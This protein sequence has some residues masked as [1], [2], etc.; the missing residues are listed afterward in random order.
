MLSREHAIGALGAG[1]FDV[2]MIGGGLRFLQRFLDEARLEG[3]A[4]A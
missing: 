2:A 4:V 1:R 3:I